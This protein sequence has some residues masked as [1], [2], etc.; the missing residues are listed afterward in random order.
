MSTRESTADD[1]GPRFGMTPSRFRLP[2]QL[3]RALD[4]AAREYGLSKSE[5][6][7]QALLLVPKTCP[8][9]GGPR[10]RGV[11]GQLLARA[12]KW[13]QRPRTAA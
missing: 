11:V 5:I 3:D 2:V 10:K 12:T 1:E 6:V 8:F 7:R 13:A 4:A 9:C